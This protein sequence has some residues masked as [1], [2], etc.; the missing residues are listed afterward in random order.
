METALLV[1]GGLVG[2]LV[3]YLA[4]VTFWPGLSVEVPAPA[5][6]ASPAASPG[7]DAPACRRDVGFEVGGVQVRA[8]LYLPEDRAAPVPCVVM[9]HGLGGTKD[10]ALEAYALR[11]VAAGFA[12][13]TFDYRCFGESE[14]EPRQLFWVPQQLEDVTAAV[15]YARSRSEI[16]PDRIAVWG[17]SAGGG[18]GITL[19]ASD[20]RIAAVVSQ[21]PGLDPD[22]TS[23]AFG[24][25]S[26]PGFLLR[27]IVHGQRD[28]MRKRLGLSPHR[29]PLVG[30]PG[31]LAMMN[32]DD[33][34]E[35]M[36]TLGSGRFVNS[37]CARLILRPYRPIAD[38]PKVLCPVLLH[39][40]EHD[41]LT[42]A[43]GGEK[44]AA[45]LGARAEVRVYPIGHFDIYVGPP[46]EQAVA[47]QVTFLQKHLGDVG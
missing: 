9:A 21:V 33:A 13:L 36:T 18:Y 2:A 41:T 15:A 34:L 29:I 44:M 47:D 14:G 23:R 5:A 30:R 45:A 17:T 26:G 24:R 32:T 42:P 3:L 27:L 43:A 39:L 4:F 31:T 20:S 25:R 7:E 46:F 40:A 19:A 35:F 37:V 6:G 10:I 12:V 16:D 38:A 8:W 22:S 28:M 11:F 1:V